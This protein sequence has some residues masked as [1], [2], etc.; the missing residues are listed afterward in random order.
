VASYEGETVFE[1]ELHRAVA[2]NPYLRFFVPPPE[3]GPLA[4]TW[5]EDTGEI[6]QASALVRFS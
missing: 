6:A 1:A 2:A 5:T 3:E 4:F